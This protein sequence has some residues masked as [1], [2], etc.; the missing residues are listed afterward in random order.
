MSSRDSAGKHLRLSTLPA[1]VA[2][3]HHATLSRPTSSSTTATSGMYR[4]VPVSG[5]GGSFT[6]SDKRFS[7]YACDEVGI[8]AVELDYRLAAASIF[9]QL[10][11][12]IRIFSS[13]SSSNFCLISKLYCNTRRPSIISHVSISTGN[14]TPR[15]TPYAQ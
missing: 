1:A 7:L 14:N 10:S 9:N 11:F 6:A 5:I 2:L 4:A 12:A 15:E 13:F 3:W 8:S